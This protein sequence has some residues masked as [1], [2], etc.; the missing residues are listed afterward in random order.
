MDFNE[1]MGIDRSP[2]DQ[3]LLMDICHPQSMVDGLSYLL[4]RICINRYFVKFEQTYGIGSKLYI[5]I[6]RLRLECLREQEFDMDRCDVLADVY[7]DNSEL[8][9]SFLNDT[10]WDMFGFD[11]EWLSEIMEESGKELYDTPWEE[12]LHFFVQ[13]T[14]LDKSEDI[15]MLGAGKEVIYGAGGFDVGEVYFIWNRK[16]AAYMHLKE[17]YKKLVDRIIPEE[18]KAISMTVNEIQTPLFYSWDSD[19][20]LLIDRYYIVFSMGSNGYDYVSWDS[21]NYNALFSF[22]VL[23]LLLQDAM[24]KLLPELH[25]LNLKWTA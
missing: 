12:I 10:G 2:F 21:L 16:L 3:D 22:F 14:T 24:K 8:F 5:Y 9:Y 13:N 11:V 1:I 17:R 4:Y 25:R 7:E 6:L 20:G 19:S 15:T 23:D 18:S